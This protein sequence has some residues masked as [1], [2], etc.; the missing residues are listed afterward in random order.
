MVYRVYTEKK[1]EYAAEARSVLNDVRELLKISRLTGVRVLNRYDVENISRELFDYSVRTI[2]SE[3]QLDNVHYSLPE[4]GARIF[5]VEFLPGQYDQRADSASQC[6]QIVSQGE[7]PL[8]KSAKVYLL[9]GELSD[10]DVKKI[11]NHLINPVESRIASLSEAETLQMK[12]VQPDAVTTVENFITMTDDELKTFLAANGLAMDFDD[13]IFCRDYFKS[14]KRNPTITEIKLI[15][16][17]WSDHCRHTTFTTHIDGIVIDDSQT[18]QGYENYLRLRRELGRTKPVTL[19]DIATISARYLKSKGILKNL[20]ESDEINA[21]TVKIDVDVN[22]KDEEYLLLFKNETHNHPTEIEPFG[23]AATCIGGA[24]RDPLSGRS[25]VYQAMRVTGAADPLKPIEQTLK[26]KLPQ[27]TIVTEAAHGYSSYG[28]QIG[29]STGLVDE[30]YHDGYAAKRMEIGAVLGAAPSKNVKRLKPAAGDVIVLL[31]GRTGRD[32]CGGATG[33]SK[34]HTL[35]SLEQCGAEV[36]KGNAPE[37]RKLQRLFRNP[38]A[39][40]LIK[41]C[42]D[43]GAGGVSVAIGELA[44]GLDIDLDKVPKKYEGLDGTELAISESQERMAVLLDKNDVDRF[45]LLAAEENIEAT[46]VAVVTDTNRLRMNWKGNVIVDISRDFLNSN[47]AVKHADVKVENFETYQDKTYIS[48]SEGMQ[49]VCADLNVCSK[50]GLAERFDATIGAGSVLMPF[51]GKYQMTPAQVMAAKIP[52][53]DGETNTASVF[54]YGFNPFVSEANPYSGSYNAVVESITK[55]I[56]AGAGL[57]KCYLT[58]Q[59]YFC[60]LGRDEKR[61]GLP[62]A[63]LLGALQAQ[64]DLGIGAIGG[65]D[66]MSGTFENLDVP[67]TLVSFAVSVTNAKNIISP[68]FKKSGSRVVLLKTEMKD[69]KADAES[70]KNNLSLAYNLISED[71]VLSAYTP[72]FGGVAAAI[73]KMCIGNKIGFKYAESLNLDVFS[74]LCGSIILELKG[75]DDIGITLGYTT[76]NAVIEKNGEVLSLDS[77]LAAYEDKLEPVFTCNIKQ[78]IEVSDIP[79]YKA[80]K[81]PAPSVKIAKPRVCIPVFPGNNCEYDCARAFERAGAEPVIT[82]IKNLTGADIAESVE[83]MAKRISESQMIMI[84]GGFSGG[85]EPDGSA[86]FITAFFRNPKIKEQL[87]ILLSKRDGLIGGICNGFQALIKLGLVPFGKIIEPDA[88]SPTLGPNIIGRHQSKLV[89]TKIISNKSPWFMLYDPGEMHTVAISHGEGRFI[90]DEKLVKEL[91][92]NGQI[93]TQYTDLEGNASADVAYNPN[94]SL[95]AIEGITSPD[96]RIFGKMGH[97]E[98]AGEHL[99]KNVPQFEYNNKL[100]EGAVKYFK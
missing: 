99:Y 44:D 3:P 24:I 25:Y 13:L 79:L 7:R 50:R 97:S 30:I 32:G 34:S 8:V 5:A 86:K 83:L 33:S 9:Y 77:L 87:E 51:G 88:S 48:F 57:D 61:W 16:T 74:Y 46:M 82:V 10:E 53:L 11:Q 54:A 20:D 28:N 68:E 85:D 84:P 81:H 96:G 64:I 2:F 17:Y 98:R 75:D 36:Q 38:E 27:R 1:E 35:E 42:N 71:K 93:A 49:A 62:F 37:E 23:G 94:G 67:P 56:S 92:E 52:V 21:C 6:I 72:T 90:C 15:D 58:F 59:E 80:D 31:G 22:G 29:L 70:L 19:M 63:A 73:F 66:S 45:M 12:T 14:E 89:T 4:D 18:K 39:S 69:G 76:E 40:V 95:L 55:L 65:K 41:K 26:G 60:R 43:F 78:D 100:F 91:I 47:G